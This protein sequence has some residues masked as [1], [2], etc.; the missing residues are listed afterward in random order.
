MKWTISVQDG[1]GYI[2]AEVSGRVEEAIEEML[3]WMM[4]EGEIESWE[5]DE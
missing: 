2:E 5:R 1:E 3:E 4:D